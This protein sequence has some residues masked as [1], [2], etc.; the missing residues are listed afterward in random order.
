MI[1]T[2][3]FIAKSNII[4][5]DNGANLG[6]NPVLALNY[7][8]TLSR[9]LIQFD[10]D[11]VRE[12]VEDKTYPD[13]SKLKH[14]LHM[15]NYGS[16][17][18]K[19]IDDKLI[20]YDLDGMAKRACSFDLIF[21]LIPKEWD[22]GRGFDYVKDF[23]I[24]SV[25]GRLSGSGSTW[26]K[27]TD[28]E[29]WDEDG[30]YSTSTL[31][32]EYDK[33]TSKAGNLSEIIIGRQHFDVGN[34]SICLDITDTFNR[35]LTGELPN[36][37][38]GI[39]Y[40]PSLEEKKTKVSQYTA[41]FGPHT[42][43]FFEPY[44]ETTYCETIEDDRSSFYLDKPNRL[45]F[46]ANLGGFPTN[47]DKE[48]TCI[49]K[50]SQ[51]ASIQATRGVYY[52]DVT[53]SSDEC[54]DGEVVYDTWT[55]LS[56]NGRALK[57]VELQFT[58]LSPDGYYRFGDG[59]GFPKQFV[60]SVS[61]I[62]FNERIRQG[63]VRKVIIEARIPY[64]VAQSQIIDGMYYRIYVMDG[65][66][67]ID[68]F[69]L[70]K[71]ERAWNQNYFLIDTSELVPNRYVVDVVIKSDLEERHFRELLKFDVVDNLTEHYV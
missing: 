64:T 71:C 31:S 29:K 39:A 19:R 38:I 58:C 59:D 44:V 67:E 26:Y 16:M 27:A 52:V 51:I 57:D 66:R 23:F 8:K 28:M 48:P 46:Y 37:G 32:K 41:F 63:D 54:E 68:V 50:S 40:V 33:F 47:L 24:T 1:D 2:H 13:I 25:N 4:V 30:V 65:N 9:V 11:K 7:G 70:R 17:D 10:V 56:V 5:K 15:R 42:N 53:L 22:G 61:G 62:R 12:R 55:D 69:T 14:V 35:F 3:T 6:L 43:T 45:Y 20:A 34:E 49:V 21:F 36:Y 18:P 60:P